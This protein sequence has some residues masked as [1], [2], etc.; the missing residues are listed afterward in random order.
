[1]DTDLGKKILRWTKLEF[2]KNHLNTCKRGMGACPLLSTQPMTGQPLPLL[3][4]AS[5]GHLPPRLYR[6]T[7]NKTRLLIPGVWDLEWE[8]SACG[9]RGISLDLRV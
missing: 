3:P 8:L 2:M 7:C 6:G 9:R 1:M 4:R 5:L